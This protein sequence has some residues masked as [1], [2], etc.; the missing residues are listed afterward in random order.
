[1]TLQFRNLHAVVAAL[2][3]GSALASP[4]PLHAE[5][6]ADEAA[7]L[8]ATDVRLELSRAFVR[9]VVDGDAAPTILVATPPDAQ[10]E[11]SARLVSTREGGLTVTMVQDSKSATEPVVEISIRAEQRLTLVGE[12]LRVQATLATEEGADGPSGTVFRLS[13]SEMDL[14]GGTD[15]HI[16]ARNSSVWL[17]GSGGTLN[18]NLSDVTAEVRRAVGVV[19][20]QASGS[21]VTLLDAEARL[22]LD[23]QSGSLQIQ[24]GT[25]TMARIESR[26]AQVTVERWRGGLNTIGDGGSLDLR[27][28]E[29]QKPWMMR[30]SNQIVRV[31]NTAAPLTVS[32]AG[33]SFEGTGLSLPVRLQGSEQTQIDISD[34]TANLDLDLVGGA[35]ARITNLEK[36]VLAKVD[37]ARL[38][39]DGV[40][41]LTLNGRGLE[42]Q[43][44]GVQRLGPVDLSD[45]NVELDLSDSRQ[46]AQVRLQG[47]GRAR[48]ALGSP[49]VVKLAPSGGDGPQPV[50]VGCELRIPGVPVAQANRREIYGDQRPMLFTLDLG[51]DVEVEV[52]GNP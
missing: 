42:L 5:T 35:S 13:D 37:D 31:E 3:L 28:N 41:L 26:Q 19:E 36:R 12:Q 27:E 33:G 14:Q 30:G 2:V 24:G 8:D 50:V 39:L 10:Q 17:D 29:S 16:E 47:S 11:A 4:P 48:F 32:S 9:L 38:T 46:A 15:L 20:L 43:A 22:T 49:C 52:E 6:A 25:G 21:D 1:M 45:S 34:S 40:G 44:S 23:V 18:L 7:A 51:G